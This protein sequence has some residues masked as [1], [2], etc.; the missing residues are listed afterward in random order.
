VTAGELWAQIIRPAATHAAVLG[1][2]AILGLLTAA[3]PVVLIRR[4]SAAHTARVAERAMKIVWY[5]VLGLV[6]GAFVVPAIVN[7]R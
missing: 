6:L 4:R 7:N 1:A 2:A 5:G 3:V